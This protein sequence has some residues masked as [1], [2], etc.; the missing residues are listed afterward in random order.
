M[1]VC[2]CEC[3]SP[4]DLHNSCKTPGLR[5]I[6]RHA[7]WRMAKMLSP[8]LF[9]VW[10]ISAHF[11]SNNSCCVLLGACCMSYLI[12]PTAL[13]RKDLLV[14]FLNTNAYLN[15]EF[16]PTEQNDK[17]AVAVLKATIESRFRLQWPHWTDAYCLWGLEWWNTSAETLICTIGSNKIGCARGDFSGRIGSTWVKFDLD[18][19]P[20]PRHWLF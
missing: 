17:R 15:L 19:V 2:V 16:F 9:V 20:F 8:V 14:V 12:V 7:G 1:C 3:P 18:V 4:L 10:F 11:H 13:R 6:I 5:P